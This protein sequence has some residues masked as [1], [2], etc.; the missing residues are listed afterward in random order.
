MV[1]ACLSSEKG[2]PPPGVAVAARRMLDDPNDEPQY[3]ERI[4]YII[5]RGG[6]HKRLVERAVTPEEFLANP[7]VDAYFMSNCSHCPRHMHIDA[8]YYIEKVLIPPLERIFNLVGADVRAWYEEMPKAIEVD[9]R[10][11]LLFSPKKPTVTA[12]DRY[13][14][15]EHFQSSQCLSCEG[16]A[17]EG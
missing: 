12:I 6:P 2:P 9:Q 7:W 17:S 11:P 16:P 5:S 8:V 4:P 13:K 10:D 1:Y 3:G 15:D 14:I